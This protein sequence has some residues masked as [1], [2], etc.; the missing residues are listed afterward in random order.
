MNVTETNTIAK[1]PKVAENTP[2]KI[3]I[4]IVITNNA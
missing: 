3:M 2:K 1:N 4:K